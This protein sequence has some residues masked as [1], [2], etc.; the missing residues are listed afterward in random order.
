MGFYRRKPL[1]VAAQQFLPTSP[2][3][4]PRGVEVSNVQGDNRAYVT[5]IHGQ[6]AFV[7]PG[8]WIIEERDGM[9]FYLCKPDIFAATY[10]AVTE[11]ESH[12]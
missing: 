12:A 5:T 10:E 8:D 7:A 2:G 3:P 4:W 11:E 6:R 9:H 1:V